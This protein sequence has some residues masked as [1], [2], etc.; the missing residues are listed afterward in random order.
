MTKFE[1]VNIAINIFCYAVIIALA[2]W[3]FAQ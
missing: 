2:I 3:M 1:R